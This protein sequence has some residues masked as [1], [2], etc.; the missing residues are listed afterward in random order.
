[1]LMWKAGLFYWKPPLACDGA[2]CSLLE[3]GHCA[4]DTVALVMVDCGPH[5]TAILAG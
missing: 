3:M 2:V 5:Y 1:M 4:E